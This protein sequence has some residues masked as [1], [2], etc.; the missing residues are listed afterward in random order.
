MVNVMACSR[1]GLAD[2]SAGVGRL[3][4]CVEGWVPKMHS[5]HS[6]WNVDMSRLL[7][8][9]TDCAYLA[10]ELHAVCEC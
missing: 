5:G 10:A 4:V 6:Y 9:D 8:T 2:G 7:S 3:V 1:D